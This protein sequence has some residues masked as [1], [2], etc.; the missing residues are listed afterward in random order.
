ME[1]KEDLDKVDISE[2]WDAHEL[3]IKA[4]L[5]PLEALNTLTGMYVI[6]IFQEMDKYEVNWNTGEYKRKDRT[7][8]LNI[9][10]LE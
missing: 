1:K 2:F 7:V 8:P 10:P 6:S 4:G 9:M 5:D 3:Y